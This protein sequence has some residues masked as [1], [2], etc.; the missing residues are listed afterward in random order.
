MFQGSTNKLMLMLVTA[1]TLALTTSASAQTVIRRT[2]STSGSTGSV[3]ES[4]RDNSPQRRDRDDDTRRNVRDRNDNDRERVT[5]VRRYSRPGTVVSRLPERHNRVVVNN[6]TYYRDD[7]DNFYSELRIGGGGVNFV[8]ARPPVGTYVSYL[9]E[10]YERV[11]VGGRRY[12][13]YDD[14]YYDRQIIDGRSRY[15]IIDP[16]IGATIVSLPDVYTSVIIGGRRYI[17]CGDCFFQ[18]YLDGGRLVYVR[19][20]SPV[21][22]YVTLSGTVVYDRLY[23][24]PRGSEAVVRLLRVHNGQSTVVSERTITTY[25]ESSIPFEFGYDEDEYD[26]GSEYIVDAQVVHEGRPI[27]RTREPVRY[28]R[29][30]SNFELTLRASF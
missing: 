25:G 24:I 15:V 4:P 26:P 8:L 5:T 17:R 2:P 7:D 13:I 27:Y 28:E 23:D 16:P 30:R 12:Y 20:E 18:P 21:R 1:G 22:R 29:G 14:I 10:R 6:R 11:V 9:P 3:R 19:V